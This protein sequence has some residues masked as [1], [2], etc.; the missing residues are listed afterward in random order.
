MPV[1]DTVCREVQGDRSP[2]AVPP[3][4][5]LY[6]LLLHK[7]A[8]IPIMEEADRSD[9][10]EALVISHLILDDIHHTGP[11][12]L[13]VL[14]KASNPFCTVVMSME[15]YQSIRTNRWQELCGRVS[16]H[17]VQGLLDHLVLEAGSSVHN[18]SNVPVTALNLQPQGIQR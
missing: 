15:R 13:M 1:Q 10:Q 14:G 7:I 18:P 6:K 3:P 16:A 11:Q 9:V 8:H 2:A 4:P 17:Q 12:V 5:L